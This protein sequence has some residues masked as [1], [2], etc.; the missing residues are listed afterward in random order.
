MRTPSLLLAL[1]ALILF[2]SLPAMAEPQAS[3]ESGWSA[4]GG[5]RTW[6]DGFAEDALSLI[7]S[8]HG[9][10]VGSDQFCSA[11]GK[12]KT[13]TFQDRAKTTYVLVES[14]EGRGTN[15]TTRFLTLYRLYPS[16]FEIMRIPLSWG[17]GPT[18]RF[19]YSYRLESQHVSG[20]RIL[21]NGKSDPGNQCCVPSKPDLTID[22]E[23]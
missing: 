1:P 22:I 20:L 17:T 12:A 23:D 11:Y 13:S 6:C 8:D 7:V 16:L 5:T 9:K 15:A 3:I 4:A 14:G 21:L 2:A 18:E 10:V 19:T